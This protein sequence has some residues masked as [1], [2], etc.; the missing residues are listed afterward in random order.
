MNHDQAKKFVD[1]YADGRLSPDAAAEVKEHI[2]QCRECSELVSEIQKLLQK[3]KDLPEKIK[4]PHDLWKD[5]FHQIHDLKVIQIKKDEIEQPVEEEPD[6]EEEKQKEE[7]RKEIAKA[8]EKKEKEEKKKE[9]D[10]KLARGEIFKKNK[11]AIIIAASVILL[12]IAVFLITQV[13]GSLSWEIS[14]TPGTFRINNQDAA[15]SELNDEDVLETLSSSAVVIIPEIGRVEVNPYSRIEKSGN[16]RLK[17]LR[18]GITSVN[19]NSKEYLTI[20]VFSSEIREL[21]PGGNYKVQM[22]N[23]N[24]ADLSILTGKILVQDKNLES[25]VI[26]NF[27]STITNAGPEIPI[28]INASANLKTALKKLSFGDDPGSLN[29]ALNEAAFSDALSLWH[30]FKRINGDNID[31]VYVKLY[32]LTPP[33]KG[34]DQESIL[35]LKEEALASWMKKIEKASQ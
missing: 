25:V 18:G 35:R 17:L 6:E 8:K 24:N 16:Q 31:E 22:N 13:L 7:T 34:V 1:E 9:K 14:G 32:S 3:M 26:P 27:T 29:I 15:G 12:I 5:V 2:D 20:E 19:Q 21:K 23:D 30:L 28:N 10:S 11:T 4:P 33:P